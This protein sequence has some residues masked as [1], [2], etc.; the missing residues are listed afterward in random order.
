MSWSALFFSFR[1]RVGRTEYWLTQVAAGV[2]V[3]LLVCINRMAGDTGREML[4]VLDL[5][6][7]AVS[8]ALVWPLLAVSVKRWHDLDMS[9]WWA[10]L[11]IVPVLGWPLA[12]IANGFLPGTEGPNRFGKLS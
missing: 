7:A 12:L 6:I 10:L 9:G 2:L 4:T 3:G 8:L 11:P 5:V 1:G